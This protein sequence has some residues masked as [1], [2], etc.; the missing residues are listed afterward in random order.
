MLDL[1]VHI[2]QFYDRY[3]SPEYV[4]DLMASLNIERYAVSSTTVCEEN[5]AKVLAEFSRLQFI[6]KERVIPVFWIT[7]QM[8]DTGKLSVFLESGIVWKC[9][10]V[11]PQICPQAWHSDSRYF[12]EVVKLARSLRIPILIH[13]GEVA[14]CE[15]SR[16]SSIIRSNA[17]I[18][19][20]LAHGRPASEAMQILS[21]C[22]NVWID[23]AFMETETIVEFVN[24]GFNDR[25]LWGTDMCIPQHYY[26]KLDMKRYYFEILDNLKKAV[27]IDDFRKITYANGLKLLGLE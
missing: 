27:S 10:K 1:H 7:P 2:G 5:Y 17:D 14:G 18:N 22:C 24:A 21:L 15:S 4:V 6:A 11:H 20:I 19:F 12:Q 23:T 9:L 26:P 13:T 25:V 8:I 16:F 3:F